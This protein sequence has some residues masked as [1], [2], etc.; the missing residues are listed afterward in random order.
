MRSATGA[1]GPKVPEALQKPHDSGDIQD[2]SQ[3]PSKIRPHRHQ[4][5]LNWLAHMKGLPLING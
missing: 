3:Y 5:D 2:A 1:H 4:P